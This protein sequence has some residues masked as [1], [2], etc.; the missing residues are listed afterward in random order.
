ME[1]IKIKHFKANFE[2]DLMKN[3]HFKIDFDED[4]EELAKEEG[5]GAGEKYIRSHVRIQDLKN[6]EYLEREYWFP[7]D[8]KI[9]NLKDLFINELWLI[10]RGWKNGCF[11]DG[12]TDS[13]PESVWMFYKRTFDKVIK[14]PEIWETSIF[15]AEVV[16][17][18]PDGKSIILKH[19]EDETERLFLDDEYL[20]RVDTNASEKMDI[21]YCDEE[22][23]NGV[24]FICDTNRQA[25]FTGTKYKSIFGSKYLFMEPGIHIYHTGSFKG[26]AE[27]MGMAAEKFSSMKERI[28]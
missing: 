7:L 18:Q 21:I 9:S 14:G 19:L 13:N 16:C 17:E 23:T 8:I 20:G 12:I 28:V 1:S 15:T 10:V 3:L 26:I 2:I 5:N 24:P 11:L 25:K 4:L 27:G 22:W 6:D